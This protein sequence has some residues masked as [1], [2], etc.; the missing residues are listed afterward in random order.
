M[1]ANGATTG[2]SSPKKAKRESGSQED[3]SLETQKALEAIDA[4]QNKIDFLNEKASEEILKV[5]QK[6]NKLRKP[7]L[8][9]RSEYING[10]PNF[11]VTT[12]INHPQ[13]S[14]D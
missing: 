11:W 14:G 4:C 5:E 7:H 12:F 13:I 10:I 6:Y 3:T 8:D 2:A 1:A 9:Q